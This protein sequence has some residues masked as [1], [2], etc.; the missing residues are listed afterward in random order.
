[1]V[2]AV[3][4][5]GNGPGAAYR[6]SGRVLWMWVLASGKEEVER[7]LAEI[8]LDPL[9]CGLAQEVDVIVCLSEAMMDAMND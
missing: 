7:R 8:L 1:M 2:L 6:S 9:R 4:E 3:K 5:E